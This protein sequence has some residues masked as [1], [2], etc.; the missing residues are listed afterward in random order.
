MPASLT[1]AQQVAAAYPRMESYA[2]ELVDTAARVNIDP[3]WLA[4]IIHLESGGNPQAVN[5]YGDKPS[6]ATGLIQFLPSVAPQFGTTVEALKQMTGAQQ[7]PYVEA[8]FKKIISRYGPLD[9]QEKVIAAV[10]Y[11]AYINTPLAPMSAKVQAA[12]PGITTIRDYTNKLLKAARLPAEGIGMP[13]GSAATYAWVT[14]VI[15]GVGAGALWYFKPEAYT[16][17]YWRERFGR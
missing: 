8:Y 6:Y 12:N 4:N 9:S 5:T 2:Q 10:F 15:M 13:S 3:A 1:P 11:P 7:M 14:L 17:T 16:R